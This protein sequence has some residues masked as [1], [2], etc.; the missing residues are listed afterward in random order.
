MELSLFLQGIV[1][2]V[3]L[4]VFYALI[5]LG[6]SLIFGIMGIINFSHGQMYMIGGFAAYYIFSQLHINYFATL[7]IAMILVGLLGGVIE[8]IIFRRLEGEELNAFIASLGLAWVL[9]MLAAII[10]GPLDKSVVSPFSGVVKVIG[11]VFTTQR[12]L[13]VL[14]GVG[15]VVGLYLFLTKTRT[16]KAIRAVAQNR[17]AATLQGINAERIGTLSFAIG[18]ALAG[19]AGVLMTPAFVI[20]PFIGSEIILKCFVVII[21]GGMGS[22]MGALAGGLILGFV[23]SFGCLFLTVPSV[24][25]IT[26]VI[27][28]LILLLRPQGLLG[29]G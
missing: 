21:L 11:V 5:A 19:A 7:I 18:C 9:E 17:E 15:L 27:V 12:L 16:G 22:I 23:E 26:F 24:T 2:G 1:N 25:L 3:M 29:H 8:R 10:S 13:T 14:V 28:I 6:L 20:N 4:G